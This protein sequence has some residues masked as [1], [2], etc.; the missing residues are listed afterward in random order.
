M[1]ARSYL[2]GVKAED[3]QRPDSDLRQLEF[4]KNQYGPIS[5]TILLRYQNG[6]FLPEVGVLSLDA[7]KQMEVAKEVFLTLLERFNT[8]N[9][10]VSDKS[11]KNY[12]PA[13]FAQENEAMKAGLGKKA[14]EGAMRQ[15]FRDNKIWNEPCGKPSR[16]AYRIA[17]GMNPELKE[18][19]ER[20]KREAAGGAK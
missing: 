5:D 8:A 20:C 17:R 16:P 13:L 2:K 7:V 12:A 3:G 9:R 6:M 18:H 15:L 14:L 19:F 11:G 4:K 10:T 1:R